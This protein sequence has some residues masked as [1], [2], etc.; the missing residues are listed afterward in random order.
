MN[1]YIKK[2]TI[3]VVPL[4]VGYIFG[5]IFPIDILK[6]NF[7]ENEVLNKSEYYKFIVSVIAAFITF[8]AVV[9]AL[10]KDDLR[11]YWKRPILDFSEPSQMTIEE[12][13]NNS[14]S[15]SS[16]DNLIAKIYI[17]R[18]EIKNNGNLPSINTEIFI[19]KL[20]FKEKDTNIIQQ[21]EC[22]GKPLLWNGTESTSMILP[23]GAKKLIDITKIT[24]PEKISTPD[25]QTT[26]YPSK[27]II[28]GIE[29]HKEQIKGTWYATFGLYAQNHNSISF[30]IE[31]EWTGIWKPRLTEF[32]TQYQIKKV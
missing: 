18:I 21:I 5:Q 24:A 23:A 6:P 19:E 15:G 10:F 25:S 13:N 12:F 8:C 4:V 14:E 31:M 30:K 29:N 32:K 7:P 3:I 20:E 28:G 27:V 17:S 16:T 22:Y 1:K 9:V 11:E 2:G 26:K